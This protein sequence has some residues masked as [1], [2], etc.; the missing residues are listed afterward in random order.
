MSCSDSFDGYQFTQ[1]DLA[2]LTSLKR[3]HAHLGASPKGD[4][5]TMGIMN[6]SLRNWLFPILRNLPSPQILEHVKITFSF[7]V[8][9]PWPTDLHTW[10]HSFSTELD[11]QLTSTFPNLTTAS[12]TFDLR[13]AHTKPFDWPA[14]NGTIRPLRLQ[15]RGVTSTFRAEVY[16]P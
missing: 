8:P 5:K 7:V 2:P 4:E 10:M 11:E 1:T 16:R 6:S 3:L 15:A 14:F 9:F 13:G 12:F